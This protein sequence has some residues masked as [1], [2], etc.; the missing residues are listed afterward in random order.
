MGKK[1][2]YD[3]DLMDD[4]SEKYNEGFEKME[5]V[6]TDFSELNTSFVTYYDG[7]T[8]KE[9]FDS[10]YS[11]LMNHFELLKLCYENMEKYVIDAK[12]TLIEADKNRS[13]IISGGGGG[14][15]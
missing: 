5:D 15:F 1:V 6:I 10:L 14:R 4:I 11:T 13:S 7:Q 2:K 8:N 9:I 12:N 3:S